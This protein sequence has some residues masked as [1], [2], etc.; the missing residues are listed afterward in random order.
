MCAQT[1]FLARQVL[2]G[3]ADAVIPFENGRRVFEAIR[4][5][6]PQPHLV[7]CFFCCL[8]VPSLSFVLDQH[9]LHDCFAW[10]P[11]AR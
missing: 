10:R 9:M 1:R 6:H 8:L 4:A 3:T 11:L 7:I 2:H 5:R